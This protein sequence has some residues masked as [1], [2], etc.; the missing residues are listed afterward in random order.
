[1][2]TASANGE[3]SG[4]SSS[5]QDQTARS[6]GA[7]RSSSGDRSTNETL[8]DPPS[9]PDEATS[10]SVIPETTHGNSGPTDSTFSVN[11]NTQETLKV[12]PDGSVFIRG[13]TDYLRDRE[14][15]KLVLGGE[16]NTTGTHDL[17]S[18]KEINLTN[19]FL[20]SL[21]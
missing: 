9:S 20:Y 4:G 7:I 10:D 21:D 15:I 18:N 3:S 14:S 2:D 16:K 1:M 5:I 8:K 12:E 6:P 11:G 19:K 13:D 17:T